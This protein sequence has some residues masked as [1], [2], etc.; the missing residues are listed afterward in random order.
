MNCCVSFPAPTPGSSHLFF[1]ASVDDTRDLPCK[2][3]RVRYTPEHSGF[4]TGNRV[5]QFREGNL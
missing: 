5:A 4:V 3:S 2:S 1:P